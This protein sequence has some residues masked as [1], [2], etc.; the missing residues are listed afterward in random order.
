MLSPCEGGCAC[1]HVR[2]RL[3]SAP[4]IVHCCHCR[5]CQRQTGSAFVLNAL[6]ETDRVDDF[7]RRDGSR[8]N[9]DRQRTPACHPSLPGV[10]NCALEPLRRRSP[11]LLRPR[12]HARRPVGAPA[13]CPYLHPLQAALGR[14]ASGRS[15]V[16]RLLRFRKNCGRRRAWLGGRRYSGERLRVIPKSP[17]S[18]MRINAKTW[19]CG[20]GGHVRHR[21]GAAAQEASPANTLMELRRELGSCLAQTPI[22][23][24]SQVT[25]LFT[26][27]RDG[28]LFGRPR[29]SFTHLEGDAESRRTFLDQAE[30]AV[31]LVSPAQDH[32]GLRRRGRRPPILHHPRPAKAAAGRLTRRDAPGRATRRP[33]ISM[34]RR[35]L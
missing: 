7:V 6:I 26:M 28:S 22:A 13:G 11:A 16:R 5:D 14:F 8:S 18:L 9:P 2:Y 15:G 33:I 32:A 4:M 34:P 31:E 25:I 10:Q 23:S 17:Q 21:A 3:A 35:L 20:G 30:R 27:K 24:G 12:R 29:I 19:A 1:G